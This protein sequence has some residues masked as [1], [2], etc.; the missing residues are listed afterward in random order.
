MFPYLLHI[1]DF[2]YLIRDLIVYRYHAKITVHLFEDPVENQFQCYKT[3]LHQILLIKNY[4][5]KLASESDTLQTMMNVIFLHII[6]LYYYRFLVIFVSFFFHSFH[7]FRFFFI[8]LDLDFH[9]LRCL[10]IV[11]TR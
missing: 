1:S 11:I 7:S 9:F 5:R 10:G 3:R 6:S 8:S 4:I 2:Y